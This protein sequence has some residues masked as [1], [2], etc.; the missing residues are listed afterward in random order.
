MRKLA[1]LLLSFSVFAGQP[2]AAV[3]RGCKA[4]IY[5][6][7]DDV[8]FILDEFSATATAV[9]AN[10]ARENARALALQCARAVRDIREEHREPEQCQ[11]GASVDRFDL[12]SLKVAIEEHA[13]R[14]RRTRPGG[15]YQV[16][17]QSWGDTGCSGNE[18]LTS[19]TVT[20]SMCDKVGAWEVQTDRAGSDYRDFDYA[21][22]D[23]RRCQA[24]C[25]QDAQCRAWT[26]VGW[27]PNRPNYRGAQGENPPIT[28]SRCWL[29]SAVPGQQW[30]NSCI[31]GV[32]GILGNT[33]F[34]GG[35]YRSV[36]L[37]SWDPAAC[38]AICERDV[39]CRAWT[40]VAATDAAKIPDHARQ[41]CWL[42][43]SLRTPS[44]LPGA[45]SGLK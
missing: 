5:V 41:V 14:D 44:W 43:D 15:T 21:G 23:P 18:A 30:C 32:K 6:E 35:D 39:R 37:N 45:R 38:K 10:N 40:T 31:S 42:K 13:C 19:Y 28:R 2:T 20:F 8:S 11:P 7:K 3:E 9:T 29:K 27:I 34:N 16:S 1:L 4:R 25:D 17:F 36:R 12:A 26:F 24:E 22:V 33:D